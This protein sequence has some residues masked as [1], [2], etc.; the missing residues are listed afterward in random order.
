MTKNL[1]KRMKIKLYKFKLSSISIFLIIIFA[2][3]LSINLLSIYLPKY[4]SW[5]TEGLPFLGG[6]AF[7][8]SFNDLK[9]SWAQFLTFNINDLIFPSFRLFEN[10]LYFRRIDIG[11]ARLIFYLG[12]PGFIILISSFFSYL[13]IS[14]SKFNIPNLEINFIILVTLIAWLK[15][16]YWPIQPFAFLLYLRVRN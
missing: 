2:S 10:G 14:C 9:L 15:G 11:Y 7:N 16:I 12:L 13:K 6:M 4:Y 8:N 5:L 1:I 3:I